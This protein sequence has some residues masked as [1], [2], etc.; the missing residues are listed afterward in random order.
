MDN[1]IDRTIYPLPEQ[2]AEAKA[3]RR[4]GLGVTGLA[5]ASEM[6]GMPYGSKDMLYFTDEVMKFLT[7][8]CYSA[9][10]DLAH[11]KGSFPAYDAH[12]Y[13]QSRFIKGLNPRLQQKIR[14]HGMRNSHLTSIA[15]TGTISL[16]ADNVSA[17]LEPPYALKSD[18][19]IQ[20]F[21]GPVVVNVKDYAFAR[22]VSGICADDL[23][24]KDHV[25]VLA[26]A[27]RWVD[28]SCSKTCN[29]GPDVPFEDFKDLYLSAWQQGCKGLTT[30]RGSGKRTGIITK[31]IEEDEDKASA[32]AC[33]IDPNT[34]QKE[35]S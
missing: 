2:E 19:T 20:T 24:A 31:T 5:N 30:F 13:A 14:Q 33:F 11:E 26:T 22:G 3:K 28:S 23:S 29:V 17:G 12:L 9:S 34:G 16:C 18:R 21:D 10:A 35:C 32:V 15:P 7:E 27:Q 6:L 25:S 8:E 4:M 1:V